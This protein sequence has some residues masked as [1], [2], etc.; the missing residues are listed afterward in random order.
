MIPAI[1]ALARRTFGPEV[2]VLLAASLD[3]RV[4][5]E[6][7][8]ALYR[9]IQELLNNIAQARGGSPGKREDRAGRKRDPQCAG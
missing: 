7:E 6:M 5:P 4:T 2:E 8:S 3:A 9:I 1:D